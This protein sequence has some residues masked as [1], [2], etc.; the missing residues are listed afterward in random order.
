MAYMKKL[1]I[2]LALATLVACDYNLDKFQGKS[3]GDDD[4]KEP[5]FY[6]DALKAMETCHFYQD[7]FTYDDCLALGDADDLEYE[8]EDYGSC[9]AKELV[10]AL[11]EATVED[12]SNNSYGGLVRKIS[13][14]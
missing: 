4:D 2:L 12:F 7:Y 8:V 3:E 13:E 10:D 6:N 1:P 11:K 14:D 5:D 9:Y